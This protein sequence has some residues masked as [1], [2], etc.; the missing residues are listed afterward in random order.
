MHAVEQFEPTITTF[1]ERMRDQHVD[2]EQLHKAV[3]RIMRARS[4]AFRRL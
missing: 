4:M 1:Y 3:A 2:D